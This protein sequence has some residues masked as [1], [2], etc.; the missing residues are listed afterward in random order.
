MIRLL[1]CDD[2]AEAR[3]A[4]TRV[5]GLAGS[6]DAEVVMAMMAA[7]ASA[8][9]VKGAPL[10]E[11]ERAIAGASE[12]LLRLAQGL[13]RSAGSVRY[14]LVADEL[15]QLTGALFAA[16]YL[17]TDG[18]E[19]ELA[20][21]AGYAEAAWLGA[22]PRMALR[23]FR[24]STLARADDEELDEL[25]EL[26]PRCSEA[27]AVPLA[28]DGETVGALAVAID[29]D[30]GLHADPELVSAVA[31]ITAASLAADERL[32]GSHAEAR[33][34]P[35][36]GL[37]N[38][39]AF[40]ERLERSIVT[41][42]ELG[43]EASVVLFDLDDFKQVND[44]RGD[45]GG[46]EVLR[47]VGLVLER[48]VRAD[49]AAF[50]IGGEEFAIVVDAEREAARLVAERVRAAL[51]KHRRSERLPTAS[52]GVASVPADARNEA[53]LMRKADAALYAAK[54]AG[55]NRVLAYRTGASASAPTETS[56]KPAPAEPRP[57][58][59]LVV[60]DDAGLRAL[61][62]TTLEA[63]DL[64][65]DEA[66]N[67]QAAARQIAARRPDVV[68]LDLRMPGVDGLAFCRRLKAE[69]STREIAVVLLTADDD[70]RTEA[71]ALAAG[72]DAF[73][74]KPFGP[75]RLL[76]IVEHL[77]AGRG[78]R[79][80][81][82]G[83]AGEDER[84][85][86]QLQLY[87]HDLRRLLELERGQRRLLQKAY[88]EAVT[89]LATAL[90]SK[91]TGTGAHS[92]RVQRYALDLA[93]SVDRALLDDP[94]LEYGF[95]LHDVGKIGIPDRILLKPT[96]LTSS[97]QR[98]M[99][100][101]TVLGEQMLGEIELLRG[102]GLKVVRSHHERWDGR[103]YPDGLRAGEIALGARVFA[104][105]DAL[106]AMTSNRPYRR[107]GSWQAAVSEIERRAGSQFD[108]EVVAG[109]VGCEPQLR[110]IHEQ[111]TAA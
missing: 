54:W 7:G 97:E 107:A 66:E 64:E 30:T 71:A 100:T 88:R 52:D 69:A 98:L 44:T 94:S 24:G 73:L 29:A 76:E 58:R 26:G 37:G 99:Q 28:A 81:S 110:S 108:P 23:P 12:P 65:V 48:A 93:A 82:L 18:A 16:V 35:L 90:E 74:R 79:P 80:A 6:A 10:W 32:A 41:A 3:A 36:T 59:V 92:Q 91:D 8:Y 14:D 70:A 103:G 51:D 53:Q 96:T 46:D 11:L 27:L 75:L 19:L 39:R 42:R 57:G 43:V 21:C 9:C 105:A 40:E 95:L 111:L 60:D 67:A 83:A 77:A 1:V 56:R 13:A 33:Q 61:L 2:S 62:R 87:A 25:A 85:G 102:E 15:C 86:E 78:P 84:T 101:H 89:A 72:A 17:A 31:D 63:I 106:D 68:V 5:V 34:D 20:G 55:K 38:R 22:A 45:A 49:E 4:N 109:F 104:V 50:R 47:R